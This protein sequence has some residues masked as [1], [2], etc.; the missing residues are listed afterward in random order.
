LIS[1]RITVQLDEKLLVA[2]K[3]LAARRGMSLNALIEDAVR[4]AVGSHESSERRPRARLSIS[5]RGG[6]RGPV[7]LDNTAALLDLM[8]GLNRRGRG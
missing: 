6:L 1:L 7:D 8:E 2:A 3:K 5:G 4:R